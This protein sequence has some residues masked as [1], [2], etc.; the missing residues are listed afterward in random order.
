MA[1]IPI[2]PGLKIAP[3]GMLNKSLKNIIC[4][5]LFGGLKNML[6][7]PLLCLEFDLAKLLGFPGPAAL[8]NELKGLKDELKAALNLL[9][10]KDTLGRINGGIANIQ[11]L[12]ALNGLCKI[13]MKAPKIPNV[14]N[15]IIDA[16]FAEMNAILRDLGRLSKPQLC[17]NGDGGI[18][19]GRY[20]PSSILGSIQK[21]GGRMANI[22]EQKIQG[23]IKRIQG[24]RK[25]LYKSFNRQLFP[26]FRHKT[27]L[28]TGKPYVP[29]QTYAQAG[30]VPASA[31]NANVPVP[32]IT[33][34]PSPDVYRIQTAMETPYASV[35]WNPPYPPVDTPNLTDATN[36]AQALVSN[37]SNT[38]SYPI[39][40]NGI[41]TANVWPGLI[42]PDMYSLA[43]T[44]LTP[45]DP[46]FAQQ[47]PVYDYCG[48][49]VGYTSSVISGDPE[50][51]I[52]D[53]T[54]ESESNPPVT[55][56]NFIWIAE[57]QC[58]AVSG[59]ESEQIILGRKDSY[60]TPNPTVQIKRA[61]SHILSIPSADI[62]GFVV[63]N[64]DV[65]DPASIAPEF[66]IC[67]VNA[68]LTPRMQNNKVVQFNLGLS[69][70][71]TY[72]LLEDANGISGA[73]GL[74]RRLNNPLGTNIYFQAD[75]QVFAGEVE[76]IVP[77]EDVWWYNLETTI[78]QKWVLNRDGDGE[79][80]DGDGT[81][82]EVTQAE[83]EAQW[84][85]SSTTFGA[86][87]INYLA[88]SNENGTIFGLLELNS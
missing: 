26:D 18:D 61:Y 31:P 69:R 19:T 11:S 29:G 24:V 58:W 60:L 50:D 63:D 1:K 37:L 43:V 2:I 9:G 48:K 42:G 66:Y 8:K 27:N 82:I 65:V 78:T 52:G 22:P 51:D 30:L 70:L 16:E 21:H 13:P 17:L 44:A 53:A 75:N 59:V 46:F 12:L 71:E 87:H 83:R 3:K 5:L 64:A 34:A 73:E 77:S 86:P 39:T 15:Q 28:N 45:Q 14:L 49:L 62:T 33:I 38:A 56:F 36:Q 85:G 68:D 40:T 79:V 84:F 57:R 54:S 6:K 23:L 80:I 25:A 20:N 47:D 74:E 4:A 10:V 7:G 88:Y 72:E 76:P 35:E 67:Y 81:W 41:T 32:V 55:N